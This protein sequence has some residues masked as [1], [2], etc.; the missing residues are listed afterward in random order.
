MR[1]LIVSTFM[2]LDGVIDNPM[3]TFRY[4]SDEIAQFQSADLFAS[5]TLLQGR[6]VYEGFA[7]A[8]TSRSDAFADYLNAMPKFVASRTLETANW[9]ASILKGDVAQ[10]IDSV[11]FPRR[12]PGAGH[13]PGLFGHR[14]IICF[15]LVGR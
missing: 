9:N 1:K 3:W 6:K 10:A 14:F 8:W 5:D 15:Q 12:R 11:D 2:T 7:E 4:W 13:C